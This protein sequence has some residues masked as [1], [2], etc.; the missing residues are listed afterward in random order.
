MV[1]IHRERELKLDVSLDYQLPR[2]DE[3]TGGELRERA[4]ELRSTYYDTAERS[5]LRHFLTLRR[6]EGD[7]DTGWQLKVPAG[8]A[9]SELSLPLDGGEA[10]PSGLVELLRG[11][12]GDAEIRPVAVVR[13]A[14]SIVSVRGGD[15]V[16]AEIADDRVTGT[17]LGNAARISEWRE[18]EVELADGDEALLERIATELIDAGAT[19]ARV[20]SKLARTLDGAGAAPPD[21]PEGGAALRSYLTEQARA[22]VAGDIALRQGEHVVHP[23]RVGVRRVRSVLRVFAL[24]LTP[25]AVG[26]D[27]ELSW[28]QNLL[29]D[30]RDRQV[31]RAHFREVLA[32]L[33]PESVLGPVPARIDNSLAAE[34]A[35][36][37]EQLMAALDTDRYRA[38]LDTVAGWAWQPP[39]AAD[40]ELDMASVR[41]LSKAARRKAA[42]RLRAAVASEDT[43]LLHRARK[44]AKRARYATEIL[45]SAA[46]GRRGE[47]AQRRVERYKDLQD[48]L[49]AHQDAVVSQEL[50]RRLGAATASQ[51]DENGFT[52]GLLYERETAAAADARSRAADFVS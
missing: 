42:K 45:A 29:G 27:P 50:L 44:A 31:Q 24:L 5:L 33:P 46:D 21:L 16:L 4:V 48:V 25:D 22:L 19:P 30:V 12:A 38:L 9:R 6:R 10:V 37:T 51:A 23:T 28:Y 32:D 2:L 1:S 13:T 43:E 7:E 41:A 15:G 35:A 14:R 52:F 17:A 18:L 34:E 36:A 20:S 49:G 40:A 47:R 11:V 26:F 39:F 3:L 8:D